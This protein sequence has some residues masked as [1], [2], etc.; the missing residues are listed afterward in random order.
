MTIA[1]TI[2]TACLVATRLT[3]TTVKENLSPKREALIP[4]APFVSMAI[5]GVRSL[6]NSI[7]ARCLAA[8]LLPRPASQAGL[9]KGWEMQKT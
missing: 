3:K 5:I 1:I 4:Q 8:V 2:A 9:K 7:A 6:K